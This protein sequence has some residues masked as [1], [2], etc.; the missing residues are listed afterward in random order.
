LPTASTASTRQKYVSALSIPLAEKLVPMARQGVVAH[1]VKL[2]RDHRARRDGE[3][4]GLLAECD[5]GLLSD[6][7][8]DVAR[9]IDALAN[10]GL[11][12]CAAVLE[13]AVVASDVVHCSL[14]GSAFF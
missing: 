1:L 7:L 2:E 6:V 5:L 4:I 9:V 3:E 14:L 12:V 13:R 10:A 11:A 8:H